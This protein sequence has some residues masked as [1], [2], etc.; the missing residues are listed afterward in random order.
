MESQYCQEQCQE[1]K[2][3]TCFGIPQHDFKNHVCYECNAKPKGME[4]KF[5]YDKFRVKGIVNYVNTELTRDYE[6]IIEFCRRE[7]QGNSVRI[8]LLKAKNVANMSEEEIKLEIA[9]LEGQSEAHSRMMD[10]IGDRIWA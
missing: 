6:R 4:N 10:Y 2:S 8:G 9:R 3:E 5:F 1:C 7:M